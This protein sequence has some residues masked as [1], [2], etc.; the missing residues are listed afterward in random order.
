[1]MRDL[2]G[3]LDSMAEQDDDHRAFRN[4]LSEARAEH[5]HL[6]AKAKEHREQCFAL[7]RESVRQMADAGLTAEQIADEVDR[8]FK[9]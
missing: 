7:V 2:D 3:F 5:A 1:M 6:M 9:T 4:F 8:I